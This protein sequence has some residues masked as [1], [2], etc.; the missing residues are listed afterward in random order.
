MVK[1]IGVELIQS[2]GLLI[3]DEMHL[4]ALIRQRLAQF[5]SQYTAT[6]ISGIAHNT[7]FHAVVL[8]V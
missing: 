6:A 7:Y 8:R 5:C 1:D 3:G 4:V 2:Y